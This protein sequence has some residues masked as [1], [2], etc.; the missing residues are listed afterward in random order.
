[1]REKLKKKFSEKVVKMQEFSQ[2]YFNFHAT[3]Y[4]VTTKYLLIFATRA[5][6]KATAN[7]RPANYHKPKL[8]QELVREYNAH[9]SII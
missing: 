4:G 6:P 8:Y 9:Q 7:S 2:C 3:I 1:M 5:V